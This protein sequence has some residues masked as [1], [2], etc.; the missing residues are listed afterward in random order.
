MC[1]KENIEAGNTT[2]MST[3]VPY[4]SEAIRNAWIH[5]RNDLADATK[6][7][8]NRWDSCGVYR[9][10]ETYTCKYPLTVQRLQSHYFGGSAKRVGLHAIHPDDH[11][12]R[13][14]TDDIDAH[15]AD[16]FDFF[17]FARAV[18]QE[19]T[20]QG[21]HPRLENSGGGWKCWLRFDPPQPAWIVRAW[22]TRVDDQCRAE[23]WPA[24]TAREIFPKQ[25]TLRTSEGYGHYVRLPG[26]HHKRQHWS[27]FWDGAKFLHGADAVA[28]WIDWPATS[29]TVIPSDLS[30]ITPPTP[31]RSET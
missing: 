10:G 17:D 28:H 16:P 25:D 18:H 13:F 30:P 24:P 5:S 1:R 15:D 3:I 29:P 8:V 9:S 22:M 23:G 11:T 12:T 7:L 2:D 26:Q 31:T 27:Y 20:D 14:V 4:D 6:R 21:A 19:L